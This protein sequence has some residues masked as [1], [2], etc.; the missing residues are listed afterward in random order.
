MYARPR[1]IY[2]NYYYNN[3]P[4]RYYPYGYGG[5]SLGFFYYDPY[6]WR[7][8]SWG[9]YGSAGYPYIGYGYG[10]DLG[11]LRLQVQPRDA[12]VYIDGYYAGTVDDFDGR[13]QGLALEVGGY[14]VEIVAPGY[15][16]LAFDI[17]ISPGRTTT[18]RGDLLPRP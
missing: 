2:N 9:Y 3:Y 15:E 8:N 12:E 16:P 11:H 1:G 6:V 18:Y 13:F 7:G 10:Y 4:G 17:R 5:L 14:G